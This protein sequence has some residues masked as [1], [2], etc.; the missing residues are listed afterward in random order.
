MFKG[1][2]SAV[3]ALEEAF[4]RSGG[5]RG[6][7]IL[8]IDLSRIPQVLDSAHPDPPTR[9]LRHSWRHAGKATCKPGVINHARALRLDPLD[10]I[11]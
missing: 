8:D 11:R 4:E 6:R 1:L 10:R 7:R 5:I 9:N 2:I 3:A